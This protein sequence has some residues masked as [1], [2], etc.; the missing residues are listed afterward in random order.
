[1][2]DEVLRTFPK[3]L[4][5]IRSPQDQFISGL[6]RLREKRAARRQEGRITVMTKRTI[7]KLVK[8][9]IAIRTLGLTVD[10][11]VRKPTFPPSSELLDA[12]WDAYEADKYIAVNV[13]VV[14][15]MFGSKARPSPH[16]LWAEVDWPETPM[17]EHPKRI[18]AL[19]GVDSEENFAYLMR[20]IRAYNW[21]GAY[22]LPKSC[23]IYNDTVQ[24]VSRDTVFDCA[25]EEGRVADFIEFAKKH[26]LTPIFAMAPYMIRRSFPA[27]ATIKGQM[28]NGFRWYNWPADRP[29]GQLPEKFALFVS[30]G[31]FSLR[32]DSVPNAIGV[33]IP[34]HNGTPSLGVANAGTILMNALSLNTQMESEEMIP[35]PET[36][37]V[38]YEDTLPR[39]EE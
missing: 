7:D 25:Y 18:L 3:G 15:R 32:F 4:R 13:D 6:V 38:D 16:E 14:R 5:F 2:K 20:A 26:D 1:M 19:Y 33:T 36:E 29:L 24:R 12:P 31:N 28:H 21:D 35:L 30:S 23:D 10:P 11:R 39:E 22:I 34:M 27:D 9:G 17:P 37:P 8:K